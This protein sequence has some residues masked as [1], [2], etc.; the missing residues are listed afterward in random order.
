MKFSNKISNLHLHKIFFIFVKFKFI[1]KWTNIYFFITKGKKEWTINGRKQTI[2]RERKEWRKREG[3]CLIFRLRWFL[4]RFKIIPW[5]FTKESLNWSEFNFITRA[6]F[7]PLCAPI[8]MP[9]FFKRSDAFLLY[10]ILLS[11][12]LILHL[13]LLCYPSHLLT[14]PSFPS[15][16]GNNSL[17][18]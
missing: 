4:R 12:L 3:E 7:V 9:L 6:S 1:D 10:S 18:K 8:V 14:S 16:E 11:F 17:R 15:L 13:L 2:E 5:K